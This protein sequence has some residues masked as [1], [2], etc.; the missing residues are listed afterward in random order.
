MAADANGNDLGKVNVVITAAAAIAPYEAANVLTSEQ[1]GDASADLPEAYVP[2]GLIKSDGGATEEMDQDDPIEFLQQGYSLAADPTMTIQIGLA[3]FNAAVRRLITGKTP[4]EHGMISVETY[5]PDT[6]WLL[7]YE[8]VYKNGRVVRK[9]G[10]VQVTATEVDQSE[11]GA[12]KGRNVTMTWQPDPLIGNGTT[13]KFNEWHYP[14][15]DDA[16][17]DSVTAS[18][19]S[20]TGNAGGT[21]SFTVTVLPEKASGTTITAT[22]GDDS[23]AKATVSGST[24]NVRLVSQGS[25]TI[26]VKAGDKTDTVNV[27]VNAS[28]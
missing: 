10:V 15:D 4:D 14:S 9:N 21:D 19:E 26:T 6:K 13:T 27:T 1:G 17:V 24:V 2:L 20:I 12:V 3:E 16:Q 7:F 8:E 25:T 28:E 23:I 22:S 11:R 18:K 5:T